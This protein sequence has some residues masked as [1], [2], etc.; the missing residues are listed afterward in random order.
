MVTADELLAEGDGLAL[1]RMRWQVNNRS[2]VAWAVKAQPEGRLTIRPSE[3]V[4]ALSTLTASET[5]TWAAVNGGFYED[6]PMGLVV[7]DGVERHPRTSRGGSGIVQFDPMPVQVLHRDAWTPA[8]RQAL[9]SI[10]RLVD[11]GQSL[12]KAKEG[13]HRDA[14]TAVAVAADGVWVVVAVATESVNETS[15]GAKL[16]KTVGQGFTLSEFSDFLVGTLHAQ[17]AL[18]LDGAVST[19]MIVN[20]QSQRW[21]IEGERGTI[22]AVVLKGR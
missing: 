5:G 1:H 18:N 9:Q 12:V 10:D 21:T 3:S 7:S 20:I 14:R 17:Q 11:G 6:G 8:A 19:Q 13:A 15:Q 4:Q 16:T 2:G 22:N